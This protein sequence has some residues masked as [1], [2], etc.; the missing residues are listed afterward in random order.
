M[1]K[2]YSAIW[3]MSTLGGVD[4]IFVFNNLESCKTKQEAIDAVIEF[5]NNIKSSDGIIHISHGVNSAKETVIM[6]RMDLDMLNA[7]I[8]GSLDRELKV[9]KKYNRLKKKYKQLNSKYNV[10]ISRKFCNNDI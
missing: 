1:K 6:N 5:V 10:A 4:G 3:R 2:N 8:D 7:M 9:T